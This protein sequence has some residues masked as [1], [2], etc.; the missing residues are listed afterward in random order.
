MKVKLL[1]RLRK[2]AKK[3]YW[4]EYQALPL[5]F[6]YIVKKKDKEE[7]VNSFSK[8][9]YAINYLNYLRRVFILEQIWRKLD[10]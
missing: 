7:F 1:K 10:Y 4:I 8:K 5:M 3:E 2:K 9:E 6:P